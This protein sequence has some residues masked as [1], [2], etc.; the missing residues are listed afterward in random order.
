[1]NPAITANLA[2]RLL[3]EYISAVNDAQAKAHYNA[4]VSRLQA[5]EAEVQRQATTTIDN[6]GNIVIGLKS[7]GAAGSASAI[8]V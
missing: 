4:L 8:G 1:M 2:L 7:L 5:I 6:D 3:G